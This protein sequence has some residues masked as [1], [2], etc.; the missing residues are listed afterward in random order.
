M[1]TKTKM[2]RN[3]FTLTEG[4]F[5]LLLIAIAGSGYAWYLHDKAKQIRAEKAG[6]VAAAEQKIVVYQEETKAKKAELTLAM[7]ELRKCNVELDV[8]EASLN[9]SQTGFSAASQALS[10]VRTGLYRAQVA[11]RQKTNL[12]QIPVLKLTPPV[13][14]ETKRLSLALKK[15]EDELK[16][17]EQERQKIECQ[18][19]CLKH[20]KPKIRKLSGGDGSEVQTEKYWY[21]EEHKFTF[22]SLISYLDYKTQAGQLDFQIA[23]C[24][25]LLFLQK[26]QL[27][28]AKQNEIAPA[29]APVAAQPI[30]DVAALNQQLEQRSREV[31]ELRDE[32]SKIGKNKWDTLNRRSALAARINELI[33]LIKTYEGGIVEQKLVIAEN[34][35]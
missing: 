26:E 8:I 9:A 30:L 12:N 5:I 25:R 18:F 24:Q 1:K 4:L 19:V 14:S 31:T 28:I 29:A 20:V 2:K 6:R 7:E 15:M 27:R 11:A 34:R 16:S 33:A 22:T 23:Q 3:N 13:D 17:L 35:E 32:I 10:E 21:C